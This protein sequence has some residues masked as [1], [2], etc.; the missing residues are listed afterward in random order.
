MITWRE[1]LKGS[2]KHLT[3]PFKIPYGTFSVYS[4]SD[5][6]TLTDNSCSH[7]ETSSVNGYFRQYFLTAVVLLLDL[8]TA[9]S[10]L[11]LL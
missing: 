7:E 6:N 9:A 1:P 3:E 11:A 10:V 8:E 4:V 5:T 2:M